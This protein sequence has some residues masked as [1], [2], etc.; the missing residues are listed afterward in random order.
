[1]ATNNTQGLPPLHLLPASMISCLFD[2]SL[3]W[4][5]RSCFWFPSPIFQLGHLF[6]DYWVI[7]PRVDT[8][9]RADSRYLLGAKVLFV[10]ALKFGPWAQKLPCLSV[11][12]PA[13]QVHLKKQA[14]SSCPSPQC[15]RSQSN[16]RGNWRP[17][18]TRDLLKVSRIDYHSSEYTSSPCVISCP[19]LVVSVFTRQ[20]RGCP[21]LHSTKPWVTGT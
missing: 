9:F 21:S 12:S 14:S 3:E 5:N 13:Q 18:R 10:E 8:E 11:T 20:I 2:N 6:V 4:G 15:V 16:L 7:R 17:R 19:A 1:M